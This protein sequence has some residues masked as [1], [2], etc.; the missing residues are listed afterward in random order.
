MLELKHL[1]EEEKLQ[2]RAART[3]WIPFQ[4]LEN[5]LSCKI[6]SID[7]CFYFIDQLDYLPPSTHPTPSSTNYN[8]NIQHTT[9]SCWPFKS[10]GYTKSVILPLLDFFF[11]ICF[12]I[13]FFTFSNHLVEEWMSVYLLVCMQAK[14]ENQTHTAREGERE[15]NELEQ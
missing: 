1:N 13:D 14:C 5:Q 6:I 3:H 4:R 9:L 15:R 2:S 11:F 10:M 7:H 8:H 12:S